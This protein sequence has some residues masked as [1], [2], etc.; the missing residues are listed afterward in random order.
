MVV[1]LD[2]QVPVPISVAEFSA[3][4]LDGR[5]LRTGIVAYPLATVDQ[6]V[7]AVWVHARDREVRIGLGK[8]VF[9]VQVRPGELEFDLQKIM[10]I[11]MHIAG[12]INIRGSV[13]LV[14]QARFLFCVND[15]DAAVS[16]F[17]TVGT[18]PTLILKDFI[19]NYVL[20][21]RSL[22]LLS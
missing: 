17:A 7:A 9:L 12:K 8:E 18:K 6:C 4:D 5:P 14:L 2:P 10:L 15:H 3:C 22:T 21:P 13:N 1:D 19:E 20:P 16:R 11:L